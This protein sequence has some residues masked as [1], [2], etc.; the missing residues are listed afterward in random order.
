MAWCLVAA[1]GFSA[2]TDPVI[3]HLHHWQCTLGTPAFGAY[4]SDVG[5][6]KL[7]AHL[8]PCSPCLS[9]AKAVVH[10]LA[11]E[12]GRPA[13]RSCTPAVFCPVHTC[14][15]GW[16]GAQCVTGSLALHVTHHSI[17]AAAVSARRPMTNAEAGQ[18]APLRS[19]S[20]IEFIKVS[21]TKQLD[22][23]YR[24]GLRCIRLNDLPIPGMAIYTAAGMHQP[25]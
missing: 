20:S 4:V 8:R 1:G 10:K 13:A 6:M 16:P 7:N 18:P 21:C 23:R 25:R 24:T 11:G 22:S 3:L 9:K 12:D 17:S 5:N 15:A 14:T 19:L 2:H